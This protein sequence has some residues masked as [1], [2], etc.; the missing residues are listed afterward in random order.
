MSAIGR[1]SVTTV[2]GF[3]RTVADG[4]VVMWLWRWF[5]TP[6]GL[7]ALGFWHACGV[8]L[9]V[10][11]FFLFQ[12]PRRPV[13]DDDAWALDMAWAGGKLL[14]APY[15]LGIGALIHGAM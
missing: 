1:F 4:W 10:G 8:D 7:P 15:V 9:F 11:A 2:L 5:L 3:L 12:A 6:L 14:I 13:E